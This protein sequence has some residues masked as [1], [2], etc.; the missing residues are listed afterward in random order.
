MSL[1]SK[2]PSPNHWSA[3]GFLVCGQLLLDSKPLWVLLAL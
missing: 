3:G 2:V 1:T